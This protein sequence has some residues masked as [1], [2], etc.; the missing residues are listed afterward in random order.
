[1]KAEMQIMYYLRD[2]HIDSL[3]HPGDFSQMTE[4]IPI[5]EGSTAKAKYK[6]LHT[7]TVDKEARRGMFYIA[8]DYEVVYVENIAISDSTK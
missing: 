5:S 4:I 2:I 8:S 7:Y 1:M 6:I 3:Y